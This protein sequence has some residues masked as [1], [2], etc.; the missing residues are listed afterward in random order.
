MMMFGK[1]LNSF[2]VKEKCFYILPFSNVLVC[3]SLQLLFKSDLLKS[4]HILKDRN[5][6]SI[7]CIK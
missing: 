4:M 7:V 5:W 3:F 1:H 2:S 6:Q